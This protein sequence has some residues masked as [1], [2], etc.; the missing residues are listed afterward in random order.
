MS[1]KTYVIA[2]IH[3][4]CREYLNLLEK[5]R[6]SEQDEL[7]VL[8]DVVDRGPEPVA[9]LRDMMLRPNVYPILG[10][11]DYMALMVL[12]R[13]AVEITRENWQ[14]HLTPEDMRAWL[15][16]MEEGG[17]TTAAAFSR[18]SNGEREELLSYLSEFS[19]YEEVF[20]AGKRFVLVHGGLRDFREEKPLEEYH[21][22]DLIFDRAD[23]SRRYFSDPNTFLVTGHTPTPAIWQEPCRYEVYQKNGHIALDCGCVFGGRL[24]A[25]CLETGEIV[26]VDKQ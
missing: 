10:N 7:Y 9:V 22:A 11:H 8:G 14:N 19:L 4:C 12:K 25:Y 26:Y 3:G 1:G 23:Y 24:A 6:F 18:V 15:E 13:L 21:F 2:D 17:N 5:I 16:W 20:T